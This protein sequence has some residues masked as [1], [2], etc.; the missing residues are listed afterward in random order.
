MFKYVYVFATKLAVKKTF[1]V[2]VLNGKTAQ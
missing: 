2:L 1:C